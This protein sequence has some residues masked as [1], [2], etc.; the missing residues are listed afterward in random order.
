MTVVLLNTIMST[1]VM[2]DTGLSL[3]QVPAKLLGTVAL[4]VLFLDI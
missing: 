4:A 2:H 1:V 3:A